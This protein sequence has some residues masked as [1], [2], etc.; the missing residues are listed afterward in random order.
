MSERP[1]VLVVDDMSLWADTIAGYCV[2]SD[3]DMRHATNLTTAV[4]LVARWRP[5]LILLDMHLPRDGWEPAPPFQGKYPPN[6]RS[7]AFCDQ[8]VSHPQ[9]QQTRVIVTSVDD[10]QE[11]KQRALAAGA[12][13]YYTKGEFSLDVFSRLLENLP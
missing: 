5:Q 8:V 4:Q 10:Q 6:L 13:A 3:C 2:V 11:T 9:L 12:F 7:L 1:L